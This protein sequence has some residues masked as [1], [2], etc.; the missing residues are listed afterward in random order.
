MSRRT[1][2]AALAALAGA[3][4][5]GP[6]WAD[7]PPPAFYSNVSQFIRLRPPAPT[8]GRPIRTAG[9]SV[10]DFPALAGR[11]VV[12]NFWASWCPPCG[13]EMP[14]L[15]RLAAEQPA[16][17][18]TVLPISIDRGGKPAVTAFYRRLGLHHLG[19]YADPAQQVGHIG[20][21]DP[22]HGRFPLQALPMTYL[23]DPHGK[24][25]GY[26]PGAA[27][28]DSP[29]ARKLIAWVAAH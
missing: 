5:A 10:I 21:G 24:V 6:A 1:L 28:W 13:A 12:V 2:L 11:V 25:V 27:R 29:Q 9:G 4:R 7:D 26:V 23:I 8:P 22:W 19:V 18:V 15:D 3:A 20:D 17:K 14:S 16:D